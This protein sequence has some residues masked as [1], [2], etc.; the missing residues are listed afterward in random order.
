VC[1]HYEYSLGMPMIA[2]EMNTKFMQS[3]DKNVYT[4]L[5]RMAKERG[6]TLQEFLRAVVVP[7]WLRTNNGH[8]ET[9]TSHA[10]TRN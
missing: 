8:A 10:H 9:T 2:L 1:G 3:L 7:D 5:R 6:I 4:E